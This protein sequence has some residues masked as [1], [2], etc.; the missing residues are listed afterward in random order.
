MLLNKKSFGSVLF[1]AVLQTITV[2]FV[3]ARSGNKKG[4]KTKKNKKGP[5]PAECPSPDNAGVSTGRTECFKKAKGLKKQASFLVNQLSLL[6]KYEKFPETNLAAGGLYE[7]LDPPVQQ[8]LC[9]KKRFIDGLCPAD[10]ELTCLQE[11]DDLP[12]CTA[13]S[14]LFFETGSSENDGP[15]S[16]CLD[17]NG[18][19]ANAPLFAVPYDTAALAFPGSA[20]SVTSYRLKSSQ[21]IPQFDASLIIPFSATFPAGSPD[22]QEYFAPALGCVAT[23]N[24][25]IDCINNYLVDIAKSCTAAVAFA[26]NGDLFGING[27][28]AEKCGPLEECKP[29]LEKAV[30]ATAGQSY[31]L[32]E[33]GQNAP[34]SLPYLGC[35][36]RDVFDPALNAIL[37]PYT[38]PPPNP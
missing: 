7:T 30:L 6:D 28:C 20:K 17:Y 4:Y 29:L 8:R 3:D 37:P 38:C 21:P 34:G 33:D 32:L 23:I 2:V 25:C 22:F 26:C 24:P 13:V 10:A 35:I 5:P 19:I 14:A 27:L 12:E 9:R 36:T 31:S 1:I 16:I 11:C 15:F 18:A